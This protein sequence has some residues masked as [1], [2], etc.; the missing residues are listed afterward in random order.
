MNR[1]EFRKLFDEKI[2]IL[3]GATG[4]NLM[5]AGMP[6]GVCPEEWILQH[7]DVLVNLQKEYLAAG[8]DIVY[9][10]TF[11]CNRIKLK[12]YGLED[13]LVDMNRQLVA[14]SKRAVSESG[15]GFV[16]GDIT[17]TGEM[18]YPMGKLQFE[19]LCQ[20]Y[21]EQIKVLDDAGCDLLVVETMMSLAET[22]AAVIAA[23][24][25]S[26]LPIIASLTFNE[27]GRTLYGTDPVTAVNVLQNLGVAAVGVNCS[28]GPD[29]MTEIVAQMKSVAF[30]PVF[31]KP[32]AGMPELVDGKSVYLMTPEEFAKDMESVIC[33]GAG[34]VGGCCG[35]EP[36]H[37][38]AL[39]TMAKNMEIPEVSK[40]HKRIVSSER[41]SQIIELGGAF[42]VVGERINPTGKKKLQQELRE[43]SLELVM[44]MAEEQEEK[45]ASILDI[46]VGM[47]GI[48]E[49][50]MML[51]V[52]YQVSQSVNLPLCI[53]SSS[54][55]VIE[56]ALRI[57]TGRALVN[58]VSLEKVKMEK[59]LP[60]VKK[61]GA[62]FIL[63]PLSDAG[64]PANPEEKEDIINTV[65]DSAY[66]MGFTKNDVIVDGLVATVGAQKDAAI[67]CLK[68]IEYCYGQGLATI[69]GLSNISFGL[70]ERMFVNTAFLTMAI[71]RGLTM[72]IANPSQTMLM[73]A[74]F[75]SDMLLVK[76]DS[77]VRYIENV[78]P[79]ELASKSEGAK[80]TS[81]DS[82]LSG[83]S[84]IYVDVLK[85]NKRAILDD[86][87][88]ALES[89]TDPQKIIDTDLIE[90]IN[91]VG[92][93][94][95]IKKYFLPQLISSAETMEMAIS[96]ISPLVLK[97]K[98]S[99]NMPTIVVATV[100]GDI[101]DIGKNLV[102]L[103]LRNY[104][105]NVID[106]GKDVP[107]D[108]IIS[109][110][111]E[112][113]ASIIGLSALMTTTMV[114]MKD[115]VDCVKENKLPYKVVIGG[116]V[117]TQSYADEIGAD[118]YSKDAAECVTLVK[119]LLGL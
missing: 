25:V 79:L 108:R 94:F 26:Q 35:T 101:H 84:K 106:L 44:N 23:N 73:N 31:A 18:L 86:V 80:T 63:L 67:G 91:E 5:A 93:L 115:V 13:N 83:K 100:E 72:A 103:M 65:L 15:H 62:M 114:K 47:N 95:E 6:L 74:A 77:D 75:A 8:T 98:D 32:N 10:P 118:G 20:V 14:L 105:F 30:V 66:S 69:C 19:E 76:E 71:E 55:E 117:I 34:M 53:D 37:I 104:G 24:E 78:K 64:L 4:T 51:K 59:V 22:R 111:R 54:P 107:C 7:P 21:K 49:K 9:A 38:K 70:P 96:V 85:G 119:K 12:E 16:A 60:V 113:D 41:K 99:T 48:D 17:M 33:A 1:E 116:A 81:Q 2:L 11:T 57:Y 68:T 42:K 45:G 90:A 97:D 61:Y 27:D 46:N 28:T 39:S 102:V 3:D 58:S 109:A 50:D 52:V 112:N 110:A 89:G 92:R 56:A 82:D 43:G 40:E 29:K 36:R 87:H 88:E